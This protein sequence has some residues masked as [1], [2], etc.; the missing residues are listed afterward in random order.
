MRDPMEVER[1]VLL[2]GFLILMIGSMV[3]PLFNESIVKDLPYT[4]LSGLTGLV[5][6]YYFDT[7]RSE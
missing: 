7:G 3:V 6:G 2:I 5:F 1:M 4:L